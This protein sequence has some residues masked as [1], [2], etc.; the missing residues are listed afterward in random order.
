MRKTKRAGLANLVDDRR[1]RWPADRKRLGPSDI[2]L[3]PITM[4]AACF[5]GSPTS[6]AQAHSDRTWIA[7]AP[8][9]WNN[10]ANWNLPPMPN[11]NGGALYHA[12][13]QTSGAL[14]TLQS[15]ITIQELTLSAGTINT[16]GAYM[17]NVVGPTS[18]TGGTLSGAGGVHAQGAVTLNP[19]SG[20]TATLAGGL[21]VE[22]GGSLA[23]SS[24]TLNFSSGTLNVRGGGAL[25]WSTAGSI[26]AASVGT[27]NNDGSVD[28]NITGSASTTLPSGLTINNG[29][30]GSTATFHKHGSGQTQVDS[31]FNNAGAVRVYT[32]DLSLHGVSSSSGSFQVDN[33]AT[34]SFGGGRTHNLTASSSV[35]APDPVGASIASVKLDPVANTRVN[36]GGTYN[37]GGTNVVPNTTSAYFTGDVQKLGGLYLS[38]TVDFSTPAASVTLG[39]LTFTGTTATL[40]GSDDIIVNSVLNIFGGVLDWTGTGT[41]LLE[42]RSATVTKL[43]GEFKMRGRTFHIPS[44][45]TLNWSGGN[46]TGDNDNKP[47]SIDIDGIIRGSGSSNPQVQGAIAVNNKPTGEIHWNPSGAQQL[48]FNNVF[49]NEGLLAVEKGTVILSGGAGATPSPGDYTVA[50]GAT[51]RL[52]NT[53]H[54]LAADSTVTGAGTVAVGGGDVTFGGT[55]DVTGASQMLGGTASFTGTATR[56]GNLEVAGSTTSFTTGGPVG[57]S[58][59]TVSGGFLLGSDTLTVSGPFSWARGTVGGSMQVNANGGMSWVADALGAPILSGTATLNIGA[60]STLTWTGNQPNLLGALNNSGV[61]DIQTDS[62]ITGDGQ[63]RNLGGAVFRKSVGAGGSQATVVSPAF[64]NEGGGRVEVLQ[65]ILTFSNFT[66]TGG[67][68]VVG[69][70]ATVNSTGGAVFQISGGTVSGTV[71]ASMTVSGDLS[72]GSSPGTMTIG[73]NLTLTSSGSLTFEVA[74]PTQGTEYDYL[75][76]AGTLG[77][78]GGTLRLSMLEAFVGGAGGRTFTI[79]TAGSRAG[80]FGNVASGHRLS[81]LEGN[82]S[83]LVDYSGN[84]IVL[85][86]WRAVPE[87]STWGLSGSLVAL[88]AVVR[89]LLRSR[90]G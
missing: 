35:T 30:A 41:G 63:I 80:A 28:I 23:F 83:F 13:I 88:G 50:T 38:G 86:D 59:L 49:H 18:W 79:A 22:S 84:D 60:G 34:L 2:G 53:P 21:D 52:T 81:T 73:G 29:V 78:E 85:S 11:N 10:D 45:Q 67:A 90:R 15:D 62:D 55:Y 39:A 4:V 1:N 56:V 24:G 72:P 3:W 89:R 43:S 74:G 26:A 33:G 76:V 61:I 46:F 31:T 57:A 12:L 77:L 54:E 19:A 32:G 69:E 71:N 25:S 58:G 16:G 44:G 68:L 51:L 20:V 75:S 64:V 42:A 36:F 27:L 6:L 9:D 37:V 82:G 70:G 8:G 5:L 7:T 48:T 47:A 66:Q 17:L 14:V 87:P 40:T 65:G